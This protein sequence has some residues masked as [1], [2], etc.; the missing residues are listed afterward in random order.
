MKNVLKEFPDVEYER[1]NALEDVR[2]KELGVRGVPTLVLLE[3][4]VEK[5]RIP[6]MT[7]ASSIRTLL[8]K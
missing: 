8:S 7:D 3:D 5:G 2:G 6:H 4:G 1:C